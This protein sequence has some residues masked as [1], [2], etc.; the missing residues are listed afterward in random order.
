M[1][2]HSSDNVCLGAVLAWALHIHITNLNKFTEI[3]ELAGNWC[4]QVCCPWRS[5]QGV[6]L[7][8]SG[9]LTN[10]IFLYFLTFFFAIFIIAFF[11]GPFEEAVVRL[12]QFFESQTVGAV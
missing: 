12:L 10:Q 1:V 4:W 11:T 9:F 8:F 6:G 5:K 7:L 3:M 2:F